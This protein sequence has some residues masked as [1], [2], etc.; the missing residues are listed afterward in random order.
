MESSSLCSNLSE[1]LRRRALFEGLVHSTVNSPISA[2][3]CGNCIGEFQGYVETAYRCEQEN[4]RSYLSAQ[5]RISNDEDSNANVSSNSRSLRSADEFL[6][7]LID[8][9]GTE[10]DLAGAAE[11]MS[12]DL[13]RLTQ[14]LAQM[15]CESR[16]LQRQ[17]DDEMRTMLLHERD[18]AHLQS[19]LS[20]MLALE[21]SA[22]REMAYL[23]G[24]AQQHC[25]IDPLMCLEEREDG[26]LMVNG[27]R[28]QYMPPL[29]ARC[30]S[31][32]AW[33]LLALCALLLRN[34]HTSAAAV[35]QT[36]QQCVFTR[37]CEEDGS[38][39]S[40]YSISVRPLTDRALVAIKK[41]AR[42]DFDDATA[43][44]TDAMSLECPVDT[45]GEA[46][47]TY[48]RAIL[49]LAVFVTATVQ[50]L[51][52][53]SCLQGHLEQVRSDLAS[54]RRVGFEQG[55]GG[56]PPIDLS[57]DIFATVRTV[58]NIEKKC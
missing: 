39:C 54:G 34:R 51:G 7:S 18:I 56:S 28:L 4:V 23:G 38:K 35:Q 55:S 2:A 48:H 49:A 50:E 10:R 42:C 58:V 53:E 22:H 29:D 37:V 25:R 36:Q 14:S 6:T 52:L 57:R 27:L 40:F 1:T 44:R 13:H 47:D 19:D 20:D 41:S 31:S 21:D 43:H 16:D 45:S 33:A 17:I 30:E 32:R 3:L 24:V 11:S 26:S 5:G 8:E 9:R 15:A 12:E 46:T